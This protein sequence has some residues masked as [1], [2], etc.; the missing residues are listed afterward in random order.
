MKLYT[1]KFGNHTVHC[2]YED[3]EK[4]RRLWKE[5]VPSVLFHVFSFKKFD[6]EK[7]PLPKINGQGFVFE[8]ELLTAY[9]EDFQLLIA[10]KKGMEVLSKQVGKADLGQMRVSDDQGGEG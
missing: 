6:P 7:T 2:Q 9:G 8:G 10:D 1:Y 3:E 4:A 5:F